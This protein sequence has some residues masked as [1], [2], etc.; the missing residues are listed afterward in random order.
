LFR[1]GEEVLFE[2]HL[3]SA[4]NRRDFIDLRSSAAA[5]RSVMNA[6][7]IASSR[8]KRSRRMECASR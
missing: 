5:P 1:I 7:A 4:F 3:T 2:K 6:M 8:R